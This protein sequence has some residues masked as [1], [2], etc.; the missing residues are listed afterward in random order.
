MGGVGTVSPIHVGPDAGPPE[1][2]RPAPG[3]RHVRLGDENVSTGQAENKLS[4][5]FTQ[6]R[7]IGARP[8][9]EE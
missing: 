8:S 9:H 5:Q 1:M 4:F 6:H 2:A 3:R 7:A